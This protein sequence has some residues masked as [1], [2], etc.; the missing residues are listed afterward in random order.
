MNR[1]Q[2]ARKLLYEAN[3]LE[4]VKVMQENGCDIPYLEREVI[5]LDKIFEA[6]QGTHEHRLDLQDE[7]VKALL[8]HL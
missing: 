4:A 1:K 6:Q 5:E 7:V 2:Q 3:L 8:K